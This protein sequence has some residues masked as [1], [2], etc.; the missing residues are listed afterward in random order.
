MQK[1][2]S[3]TSSKNPN[4]IWMC[5]SIAYHCDTYNFRT[6]VGLIFIYEALT[7]LETR[8]TVVSKTNPVLD[9]VKFTFQQGAGTAPQ[10][11][12]HMQTHVYT[13]N[14][15]VDHGKTAYWDKCQKCH[16]KGAEIGIK[17][18]PGRLL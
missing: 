1:K 6:F 16:K 4:D 11:R 12:T 13:Q 14:P 2:A 7:I 5:I 8:K 18:C 15:N 3:A 17:G 9:L 10:T